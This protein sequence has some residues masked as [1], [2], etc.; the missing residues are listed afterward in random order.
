VW[1]PAAA[2][3]AMPGGGVEAA[4]LV[5]WGVG[6]WVVNDNFIYV[7]LAG[8]RMRLHQVPAL[9][10]FLGGPA[11]FGATGMILGPAVLAV[12]VALLEVWARRA[13]GAA[14][15]DPGRAVLLVDRAPSAN[16][17]PAGAPAAAG[18]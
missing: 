15:P 6:S 16:G 13:A 5:A 2:Y 1:L 12:A 3:L 8:D 7:R 11:V 17:P 10:A 4:A 14:D 18:V 9:L